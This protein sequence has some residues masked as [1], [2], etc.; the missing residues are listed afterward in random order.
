VSVA[1]YAL[2]LTDIEIAANV[3][4]SRAN[5]TTN[6]TYAAEALEEY[7]RDATGDHLLTIELIQTLINT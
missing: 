4:L 6:A 5:L 7:Q 3:T 1:L 2:A